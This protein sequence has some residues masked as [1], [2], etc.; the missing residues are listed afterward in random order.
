M[1]PILRYRF[2]TE[3]YPTTLNLVASAPMYKTEEGK[4]QTSEEELAGNAYILASTL[5]YYNNSAYTLAGKGSLAN[6]EGVEYI[7]VDLI[8]DD[9]YEKAKSFVKANVGLMTLDEDY[10]G[11]LLKMRSGVGAIKIGSAFLS[12]LIALIA[13]VNMVNILSTGLLNRK[14]ELASMQCMGMTR[15]QLYGMTVVECLQYS[16]T[17]GVLAT[18]LIEALMG[19]TLLVLKRVKLDDELGDLVNFAEPVPRVWIA[20]AVAFVAAVI[21]SVITLHRINK[22]SLTDQ[23]RTVE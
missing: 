2:T 9:D 23:M 13:L 19:L 5:D 14:S 17:S 6:L 15:G 22:E 7:H 16:L 18:G 20:A 4:K 10:H 8:N 1:L 21:A 11:D 12:V 3:L